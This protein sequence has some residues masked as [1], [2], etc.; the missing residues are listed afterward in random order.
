[1]DLLVQTRIFVSSNASKCLF[2]TIMFTK[3]LI[4]V[5]NL[6]LSFQTTNRKI[7][8]TMPGNS[9]GYPGPNKDFW[10][11]KGVKMPIS[12]ILSMNGSFIFLCDL[13]QI[14][15]PT[16]NKQIIQIGQVFQKILKKQQSASML[17]YRETRVGLP[18]F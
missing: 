15:D 10:V 7:Y 13:F 9:Y 3:Q 17:F 16:F 11:L 14:N 1:M 5:Q 6:L 2:S 12:P 18:G 8:L 4:T